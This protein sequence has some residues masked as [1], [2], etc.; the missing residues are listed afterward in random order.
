MGRFY[1]MGVLVRGMAL[2]PED[3]V[4]L[5]LRQDGTAW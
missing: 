1:D 5:E 3:L 4:G 2:V